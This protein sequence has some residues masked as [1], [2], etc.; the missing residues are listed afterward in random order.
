MPRR[1]HYEPPIRS[2]GSGT[3]PTKRIEAKLAEWKARGHPIESYEISFKKARG[4]LPADATNRSGKGTVRSRTTRVDER[5]ALHTHPIYE[6]TKE[7][8]LLRKIFGEAA[9]IKKQSLLPSADD[10]MNLLASRR[11]RSSA[12][13][14]TDPL[15]PAKVAGY[16]FIR[17]LEN[18]KSRE[19]AKRFFLM[20]NLYLDKRNP[21]EIREGAMEEFKSVAPNFFKFTHGAFNLTDRR[22]AVMKQELAQHG[23]QLRFV[24]N[25]KEG[26]SLKDGQFEK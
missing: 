25:K 13:I 3:T 9:T 24:P 5:L 11:L 1:Y 22:L 7:D 8:I 26:Y 18:P 12:I 2:K 6:P 19:S 4:F 10:L 21:R 16:T 17:K 23:F 20:M 15:N 14:V